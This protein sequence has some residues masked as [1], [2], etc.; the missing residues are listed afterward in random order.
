MIHMRSAV[1]TYVPMYH[2][3]LN[4]TTSLTFY[5]N[6]EIKRIVVIMF[7]IYSFSFKGS[8]CSSLL[9]K[10][11]FFGSNINK[12]DTW[13]FLLLKTIYLAEAF[14]RNILLK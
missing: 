14:L 11:S 10:K 8:K 12:I 6:I 2:W 5:K 1:W 3:K 4:I 9:C 7:L 13:Y